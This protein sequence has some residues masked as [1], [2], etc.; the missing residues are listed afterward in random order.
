ME[1]LP[2]QG[3]ACVR[4]WASLPP[5]LRRLPSPASTSGCLELQPGCPLLSWALGDTGSP[6][7]DSPS[8]GSSSLKILAASRCRP[9]N[10]APRG[11]AA[12]KSHHRKGTHPIHRQN[13]L[14][15]TW[16]RAF[17]EAQCMAAPI[18]SPI[19]SNGGRRAIRVLPSL[20][21]RKCLG[22][23]RLCLPSR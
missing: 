9:Q 19:S 17:G 2:G 10:P 16:R 3:R 14:E 5:Q 13:S 4:A 11:C 6:W 22:A 21:E 23:R 18:C 15:H 1:L 8:A 7:L 20:L 12:M